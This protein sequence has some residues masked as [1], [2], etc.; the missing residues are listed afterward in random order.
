MDDDDE[1]AEL[2][3]ARAARTGQ[4]T[5]VSKKKF[6]RNATASLVHFTDCVLLSIQTELRE[7]QRRAA[8]AHQGAYFER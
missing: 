5:L 3:A 6:T 4:A 8:A 2:R 7:Q 1:L